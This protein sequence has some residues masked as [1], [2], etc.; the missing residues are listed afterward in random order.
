MSSANIYTS[1]KTAPYVYQ[2]TH[3]ITGEFYI[4]MRCANQ[5]PSSDD[6]GTKYKTS[7]KTVTP[8]FHEFNWV[9]LAEFLDKE[10]AF[11]F[12]QQR[13]FEC[14]GSPLMLNQACHYEN[15]TRFLYSGGRP[16]YNKG[17]KHSP[18]HVAKIKAT[19]TGRLHTESTKKKMSEIA[20]G[21]MHNQQAK[22]KI[23]MANSGRVHTAETRSKVSAAV[24]GRV[25]SDSAKKKISDAKKLY[26]AQRKEL[27]L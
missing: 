23:S 27:S 12:E 5:C 19:S 7:S 15:H 1:S 25:M 21:R 4:G 2:G 11:D 3:P 17:L 18:E 6:L 10:S 20:T 9:I 13:I 8:R 16:S 24:R 26:W 22:D 14:W